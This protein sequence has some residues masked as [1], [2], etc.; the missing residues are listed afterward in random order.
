MGLQCPPAAGGQAKQACQ[1][2]AIAAAGRGTSWL[3]LRMLWLCGK[4]VLVEVVRG[5][6]AGDGPSSSSE[7]RRGRKAERKTGK[8][9][10][11]QGLRSRHSSPS[12]Q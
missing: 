9:E 10:E 7:W 8:E 3:I 12:P 1:G 4:W 11:G 2:S 6:P 5:E